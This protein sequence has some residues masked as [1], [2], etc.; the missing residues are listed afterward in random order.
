MMRRL[1]AGV[2]PTVSMVPNVRFWGK[3]L[4]GDE[5]PWKTVLGGVC[6]WRG[7]WEV[8]DE[9]DRQQNLP[10][11]G[12]KPSHRD[13][14]HRSPLIMETE[15][16]GAEA[17]KRCGVLSVVEYEVLLQGLVVLCSGLHSIVMLLY[18]RNAI[19]YVYSQYKYYLFLTNIGIFQHLIPYNYTQFRNTNRY[20]LNY[21]IN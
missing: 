5:E 7:A 3:E 15:G 8:P 2:G 4:G 1:F 10:P 20:I 6:G 13:P 19:Q 12:P 11:L 21:Y 14:H 16:R 18:S 9:W 17:L